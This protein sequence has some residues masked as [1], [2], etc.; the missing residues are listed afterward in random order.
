MSTHQSQSTIEMLHS[1]GCHETDKAVKIDRK[2]FQDPKLSLNAKGVYA[3][4][5]SL[6]PLE[7]PEVRLGL[8]RLSCLCGCTPTNFTRYRQELIDSG[9]LTLQIFPPF[10]NGPR[11]YTLNIPVN[12]GIFT[13]TITNTGD[14]QLSLIAID[15]YEPGSICCEKILS[16]P[17]LSKR[18]IYAY[19]KS[20]GDEQPPAPK[21][22]ADIMQ[23]HYT[24]IYDIYS[25]LTEIDDT[26]HISYTNKGRPR[27][28]RDAYDQKENSCV[29]PS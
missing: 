12:E 4:L 7:Q 22:V 28:N 29:A 17:S 16:I 13:E 2:V 5:Y 14:R 1:I 21:V 6:L 11:T 20:L 19:L 27:K 23:V 18:A 9:Y 10:N 26:I 25:Y 15:G 8:K 3:T 24:T